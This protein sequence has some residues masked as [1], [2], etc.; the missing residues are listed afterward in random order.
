MHSRCGVPFT[1][2]E[3]FIYYVNLWKIKKEKLKHAR[4]LLVLI[5]YLIRFKIYLIQYTIHVWKWS[6]WKGSIEA[7]IHR[8]LFKNLCWMNEGFTKQHKN[9]IIYYLYFPLSFTKLKSLKI[10]IHSLCV[11]ESE[12]EKQ[13]WVEWVYATTVAQFR[14]IK[15]TNLMKIGRIFHKPENLNEPFSLHIMCIVIVFECSYV[16]VVV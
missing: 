12:G 6:K 9:V 7:I 4:A 11:N 1:R 2:I 3:F 15:I 10:K 5:I 14:F 8:K 16:I 13:N